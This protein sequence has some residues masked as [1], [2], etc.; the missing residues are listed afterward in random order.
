MSKFSTIL[1]KALLRSASNVPYPFR[2]RFKI[3]FKQK[4]RSK[5]SEMDKNV[6]Q[7][8]KNVRRSQT[9]MLIT[10][11]GSKRSQNKKNCCE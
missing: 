6:T 2:E 7:T 4:C 9:F 5:L 1:S 8:V 11:N 10:I 3:T